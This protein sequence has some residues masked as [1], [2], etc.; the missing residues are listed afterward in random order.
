MNQDKPKRNATLDFGKLIAAICIVSLHVGY[1]TELPNHVGDFIRYSMRW[2]VPFFF[3]S[4][5]YFIS[6]FNATS[7]YLSKLQKIFLMAA[8]ASIIYVP[9]ILYRDGWEALNLIFSFE[10]LFFGTYVHLWFFSSLLFGL[11][12][13]SFL[14]QFNYKWTVLFSLAVILGYLV[15]DGLRTYGISGNIDANFFRFLS[16]IPFLYLGYC[17][18]NP[19]VIDFFSKLNHLFILLVL[20]VLLVSEFFVL[21]MTNGDLKLP[22]FGIASVF[23]AILFFSLCIKYP[24][25]IKFKHSK[26]PALSLGIYIFHPLIL[27]ISYKF[28]VFFHFNSSLYLWASG[29]LS[30]GILTI[31]LSEYFPKSMLLINGVIP[32]K[33]NK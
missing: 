9:A 16:G 31:V 20:L 30:A 5:G 27:A 14:A 18:R 33:F 12:T 2:A 10:I 32:T 13:L 29:C 17:F 15:V 26:V 11:L 19:K 6:D 4:S 8:V 21:V 24:E 1:F 23:L 28:M 22:Q 7:R 3:I 25:S